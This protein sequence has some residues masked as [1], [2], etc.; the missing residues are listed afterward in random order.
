[1]GL[2]DYGETK[3]GTNDLRTVRFDKSGLLNRKN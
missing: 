1:M 2:E 3:I